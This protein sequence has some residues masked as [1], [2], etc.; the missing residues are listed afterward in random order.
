[1]DVELDSDDVGRELSMGL[2]DRLLTMVG[3]TLTDISTCD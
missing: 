3:E 2:V 1:M